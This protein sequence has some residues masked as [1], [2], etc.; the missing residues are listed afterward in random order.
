[1]ARKVYVR[2]RAGEQ[3][4][5]AFAEEILCGFSCQDGAG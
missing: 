3:T 1:M 2:I 5:L 4:Q